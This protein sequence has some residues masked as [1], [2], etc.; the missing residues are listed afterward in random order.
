MNDAVVS[1]ARIRRDSGAGGG[2]AAVV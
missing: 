2:G 1:I